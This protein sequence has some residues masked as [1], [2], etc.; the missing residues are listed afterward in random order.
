MVTKTYEILAGRKHSKRVPV[1][2]YS[3]FKERAQLF[4]LALIG[5]VEI[6]GLQ[7]AID[8]VREIR[9]Q[10]ANPLYFSYW[11]MVTLMIE[12]TIITDEDRNTRIIKMYK[13][14]PNYCN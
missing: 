7:Q 10:G 3:K 2:Q 6:Y 12:E 1:T 13:P 8:H 9:S 4:D 11:R 14:D 5:V